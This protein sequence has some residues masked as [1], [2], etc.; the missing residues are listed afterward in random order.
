MATVDEL[1]IVVEWRK[2]PE[3]IDGAAERIRTLC[4]GL[5]CIDERLLGDWHLPGRRL[6]KFD[7]SSPALEKYLTRIRPRNDVGALMPTVGHHIGLISGAD[8]AYSV[9]MALSF[10]STTRLPV[11][12]ANQCR[13]TI[14]E[15]LVSV[16]T[17]GREFFMSIVRC[18]AVAW[19]ADVG[20]AFPKSWWI[21]NDYRISASWL[22]YCAASYGDVSDVFVGCERIEVA[23]LGSMFVALD[24]V[25]DPNDASHREIVLALDGRAKRTVLNGDL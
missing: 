23:P 8:T 6:R 24:R 18:L 21:A 17:L 19:D 11:A 4:A 25:F 9:G 22:T 7:T 13:I 1:V 3:S 5:S 16:Q 2:R 20:L 14:S 10:G 12:R 15:A